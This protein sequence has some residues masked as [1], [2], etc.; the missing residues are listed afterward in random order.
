MLISFSKTTGQQSSPSAYNVQ[1]TSHDLAVYCYNSTIL[2][3]LLLYYGPPA[4]VD[5]DTSSSHSKHHILSIS[6]NCRH[7]G[8][9]MELSLIHPTNEEQ[10]SILFTNAYMYKMTS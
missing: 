10:L 1:Y 2:I 7:L 6:K 8:H 4:V 9:S 3:S 5:T